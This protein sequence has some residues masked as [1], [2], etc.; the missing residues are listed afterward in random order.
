MVGR[1][2]AYRPDVARRSLPRWGRRI[3]LRSDLTRP[4]GRTLAYGQLVIRSE[5]SRRPGVAR[6]PCRFCA[7]RRSP[8]LEKR[9]PCSDHFTARPSV[10]D[11]EVRAVRPNPDLLARS[12]DEGFWPVIET[13]PLLQVAALRPARA[14]S[15]PGPSSRGGGAE[16][17]RDR[18]IFAAAL[19]LATGGS[20]PGQAPRRR[21]RLPSS[22]HAASAGPQEARLLAR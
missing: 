14:R 22:P 9:A 2:L 18:P 16:P 6:R 21:A 7:R 8:G 3:A 20:S 5:A 13:T 19:A 1:R 12:A 17:W 4:P 10:P 15:P 11:V